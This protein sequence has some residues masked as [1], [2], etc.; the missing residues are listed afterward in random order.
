M[1]ATRLSASLECLNSSLAQSA[2]ELWPNMLA[3]DGTKILAHAGLP[4]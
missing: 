4:V 3:P 1:E 2:V